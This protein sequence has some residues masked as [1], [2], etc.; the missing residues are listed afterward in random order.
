[1]SRF[2]LLLLSLS[3]AFLSG[4]TT[5]NNY[6]TRAFPTSGGKKIW[7]AFNERGA[8]PVK[9]NDIAVLMAGFTTDREKKELTY[10]FVFKVLNNQDPKKVVVQ[11]ISEETPEVL[12]TDMN[13]VLGKGIWAGQSAP[14]TKDD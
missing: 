10:R 5:N 14:K 9:T 11:D 2:C 12:V 7:V 3:L 8:L 13:P 6:Q 4:C 1:M